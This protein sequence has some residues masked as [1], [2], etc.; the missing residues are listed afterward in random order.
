GEY[1]PLADPWISDLKGPE[2]FT[3]AKGSPDRFLVG[4]PEHIINEVERF[5]SEL[6]ELDYI[7]TRFRH[8]SGPSHDKAFE[9]MKMFGEKVIPHFVV[10][11]PFV[12]QAC[13]RSHGYGPNAGR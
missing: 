3:Y 5:Q 11:D 13:H 9:S 7:I 6:P 1:S 10:G 8:P 4:S 12:S 2:E